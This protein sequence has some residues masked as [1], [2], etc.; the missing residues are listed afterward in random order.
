MVYDLKFRL[1]EKFYALALNF[2][3][4]FSLSLVTCMLVRMPDTVLAEVGKRGSTFV[5]DGDIMVETMWLLLLLLLFSCL[6]VSSPGT[7][8]DAAT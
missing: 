7:E 1:V 6:I 3:A 8:S 4:K 2:F 5:V